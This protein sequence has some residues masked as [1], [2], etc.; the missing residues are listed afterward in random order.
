MTNTQ[1]QDMK[2]Y[3]KSYRT[4]RREETLLRMRLADLERR[5]RLPML[6]PGKEEPV[7]VKALAEQ[8]RQELLDLMKST[9]ERCCEIETII[10][11]VEGD[12][13]NKTCLYRQI[14]RLRYL[15][16]L[17]FS[18]I[19]DQLHYHERHVRRLHRE[20]LEAAVGL[21]KGGKANGVE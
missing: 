5:I 4:L 12:G 14:L 11:R 21:W 15:D 17:T 6:H 18:Q 16:G 19:A 7:D 13:E 10:E 1:V 20:S 2:R 8:R 3:L 9:L